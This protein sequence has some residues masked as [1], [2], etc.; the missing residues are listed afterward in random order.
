MSGASNSTFSRASSCTYAKHHNMGDDT[1]REARSSPCDF[2]N[3]LL[4]VARPVI[5]T[6]HQDYGSIPSTHPPLIQPL[7][8][9]PTVTAL[10]NL[11]QRCLYSVAF[12]SHFL[13]HC[14]MAH[15]AYMACNALQPVRRRQ[16]LQSIM[17]EVG[18]E[19]I[20]RR[21]DNIRSHDLGYGFR[22]VHHVRSALIVL[23]LSRCVCAGTLV[24]ATVEKDVLRAKGKDQIDFS[25]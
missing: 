14:A 19:T 17:H 9:C 18:P 15:A 1:T 5:Q 11:C 7:F 24:L 2:N 6:K 16:L 8:A 25:G 12:G 3:V 20:A 13:Q 10:V 4:T 21:L 22:R 23:S